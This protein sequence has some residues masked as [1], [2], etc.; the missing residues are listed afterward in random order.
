VLLGV[1]VAAFVL[2]IGIPVLAIF[3][4]VLPREPF[5][6]IAQ[7]SVV[8]EALRLSMMTT[9]LT[10]ALAIGLGTPLP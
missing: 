7:R 4:R 10:L 3:L 2:I 6:P 5:W 8:V 1:G 9:L